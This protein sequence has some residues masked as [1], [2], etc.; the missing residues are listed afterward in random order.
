MGHRYYLFG[1]EQMS[2]KG[3]RD[4]LSIP[5]GISFS[6]RESDF[7]GGEYYLARFQE[8]GKITIEENWADDE[9]YLAEPDFPEYL[10]LVYA[11]SPTAHM[12]SALENASYLQCL[13]V[14]YLD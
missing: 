12:L 4:A 6:T 3:V 1:S 7:K 14:E 13:R 5:L 9:G 2:I 10:T 8:T 11:T